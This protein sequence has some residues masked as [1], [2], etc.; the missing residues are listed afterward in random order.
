MK[1]PRELL[2]E[3]HRAASRRLDA[4][5]HAALTSMQTEQR[6]FSL[7]DFLRSLRWH[8]LG[9]GAAWLFILSLRLSAAQSPAMLAAIPSTKIP[10]PRVILASLRENRR[11]LMQMMETNT[12]AAKPSGLVPATPHSERRREL[13]IA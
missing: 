11:E 3:R 7:R 6:A 2:L 10:P 13:L 5:R 12:P 8:A 9:L 4:V 1:T